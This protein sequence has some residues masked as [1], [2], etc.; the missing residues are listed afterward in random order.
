MLAV[1]R[2]DG[3]PTA[4]PA[5]EVSTA[6]NLLQVVY[7][8]GPAEVRSFIRLYAHR[9]HQGGARDSGTWPLDRSWPMGHANSDP[10]PSPQP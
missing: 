3:V 8:H 6:D 9:H 2:V 7:D 5:A 4:F 1:K 10:D